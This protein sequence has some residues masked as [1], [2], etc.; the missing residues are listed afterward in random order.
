MNSQ[1]EYDKTKVY[2]VI[3]MP[4]GSCLTVYRLGPKAAF[5]IYARARDNTPP[6]GNM[7][8]TFMWECLKQILRMT[9]EELDDL[10]AGISIKLM[11]LFNEITDG[12]PY[13]VRRL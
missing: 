3:D 9:D 2:A 1:A 6:G 7:Q 10:P 12:A 11:E 4:D 8:D 13:K 5:E